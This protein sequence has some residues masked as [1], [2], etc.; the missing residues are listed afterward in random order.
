MASLALSAGST[1]Q[2]SAWP[3]NCAAQSVSVVSQSITTCARRLLCMICL[4]IGRYP[5]KKQATCQLNRKAEQDD[6]AC[7]RGR[8][9]EGVAENASAP[10]N[11][12]R[13]NLTKKRLNHAVFCEFVDRALT[14]VPLACIHG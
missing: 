13:S 2:P 9:I 14:L 4:R 7:M 8:R 1:R 3:Q 6:G 12:C 11:I 5:E 10:R